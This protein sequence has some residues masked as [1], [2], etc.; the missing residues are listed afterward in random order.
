VTARRMCFLQ[1]RVERRRRDAAALRASLG[2]APSPRG[3]EKERRARSRLDTGPRFTE[4]DMNAVSFATT[5][6]GKVAYRAFCETAVAPRGLS[7]SPARGARRNSAASPS[8]SPVRSRTALSYWWCV[9]RASR[10][11]AGGVPGVQL[12]GEI[13]PRYQRLRSSRRCRSGRR[14]IPRTDSLRR[15]AESSDRRCFPSSPARDCEQAGQAEK[16]SRT[17]SHAT[18]P[19]Q[20]S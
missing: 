13:E 19:L 20:Q 6:V 4:V 18:V 1:R 2:C 11:V 7:P 5:P 17:T 14:A 12:C 10:V 3:K 8:E 9:R 16:A 15:G